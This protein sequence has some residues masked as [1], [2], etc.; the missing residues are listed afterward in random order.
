MSSSEH[1]RKRER[2]RKK[3]GSEDNVKKRRWAGLP[4][5]SV[6]IGCPGIGEVGRGCEDPSYSNVQCVCVALPTRRGEDG[7]RLREQDIAGAHGPLRPHDVDVLE[8]W[9]RAV[10]L[11]MML[12]SSRWRGTK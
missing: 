5:I 12:C 3:N 7:A 2:E 6:A 10:C 8:D 9:K 4:S 1:G 11:K